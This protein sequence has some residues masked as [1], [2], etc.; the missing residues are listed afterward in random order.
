MND[1][2][3]RQERIRLIDELHSAKKALADIG[4]PSRI[5]EP[6]EHT[7]ALLAMRDNLAK[8]LSKLNGNK[9]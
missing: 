8:E 7:S 4:W 6:I 1:G 2:K 9:Q 3:N 5:A